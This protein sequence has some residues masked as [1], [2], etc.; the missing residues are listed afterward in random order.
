MFAV[1]ELAVNSTVA[2]VSV[3]LIEEVNKAQ[4][5]G[6]L[7]AKLGMVIQGL[8]PSPNAPTCAAKIQ[9]V[10]GKSRC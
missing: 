9:N 8:L 6:M 2:V 4:W 5:V 1:I 3:S 7:T 10:I